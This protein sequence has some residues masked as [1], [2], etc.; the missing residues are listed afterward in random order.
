MKIA[1]RNALT[2][3]AVLASAASLP[4]HAAVDYTSLTSAFSSTEIT[5]GLLAI[6]AILAAIYTAWKGIRMVLSMMKGG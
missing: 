3:A 6:G 2:G 4:A 5:T 1:N